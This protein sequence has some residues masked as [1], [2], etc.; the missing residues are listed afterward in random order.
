MQSCPW[1]DDE[2]L[3][4]L[5]AR[6]SFIGLLVVGVVFCALQAWGASYL[7]PGRPV[8]LREA[9]LEAPALGPRQR[10][11]WLERGEAQ[12]QCLVEV[13]LDP[14]LVMDLAQTCLDQGWSVAV[15]SRLGG[16]AL[17]AQARGKD[18]VA[19]LRRAVWR[20]LLGKPV[21][22]RSTRRLRTKGPCIAGER[23]TAEM[24]SWLGTPYRYGGD[25]RNGIDCSGLVR[26]VYAAFGYRL[27]RGSYHQVRVGR[28]VSRRELRLGDLV[29]FAQPG[30]GVVHVGIYLSNGYFL[31]AA[32]EGGVQVSSLTD[33]K[34][35]RL[36][37]GARRVA[38]V[39]S[40]EDAVARLLREKGGRV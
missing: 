18:P 40:G 20:R 6:V 23:L 13:G 27:P 11:A 34:Y 29:F 19:A 22:R 16:V 36:Y 5:A 15:F 14:G 25:G 3:L 32:K 12:V 1:H 38:C 37:Y 30:R 8:G 33:P 24:R 26:R 21:P 4:A 10:A 28:P 2:R 35:R 17:E 39:V 9:V 7:W 31:H